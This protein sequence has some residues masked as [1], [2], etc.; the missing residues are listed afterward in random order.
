MVKKSNPFL[1]ALKARGAADV[2][3]PESSGDEAVDESS[4]AAPNATARHDDQQGN[5]TAHQQQPQV[6]PL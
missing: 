6:A 1:E 4:N 3:S 2:S 5:V